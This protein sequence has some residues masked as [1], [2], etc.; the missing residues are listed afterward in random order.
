MSN[1]QLPIF[2]I[3]GTTSVGKSEAVLNLANYCLSHNL[4]TG[5]DIISADSRQVYENI[6][7]LTGADL[8]ENFTRMDSGAQEN[9]KYFSC[10]NINIYGL[11]LIKVQDDWSV[12]Q[13]NEYAQKIMAASIQNNRLICVVGGTGLYHDHLFTTDPQLTIPPNDEVRKKASEISLIELQNWLEL[14]APERWDKM[15]NSDKNNPR[16]LQRAIEIAIAISN[17][18]TPESQQVQGSVDNHIFI[19]LSLDMT[20]LT[21]KISE[22]VLSRF[23]N[24][25]VAE[26]EHILK[27]FQKVSPQVT[28]TLGFLQIKDFLDGKIS[29]ET[30]I[31]NWIAADLAYS[32]RQ[33][34]WWKNEPQVTWIDKS[35]SLWEE[36]FLQLVGSHF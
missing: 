30:C 32:K 21:Q 28:T 9:N 14:V 31:Q 18:V 3:V 29:E 16:R 6:S 23:K 27:N 26:V 7:V 22:R 24:G 36:K 12:A 25:A 5:V 34:T 11:S 33:I 20:T 10:N 1:T 4:A 8:P 13:F 17:G 15:N 19:G 35:E 2:S